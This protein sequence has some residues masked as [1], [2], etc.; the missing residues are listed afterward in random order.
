MT[1]LEAATKIADARKEISEINYALGRT[2]DEV[3]IKYLKNAR[4]AQYAII[5][6]YTPIWERLCK[7]QPIE[8][9]EKPVIEADAEMRAV[10]AFNSDKRFKITE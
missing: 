10:M 8:V 7:D 9:N 1:K 4:S 3:E 5:N 6:E 2:H